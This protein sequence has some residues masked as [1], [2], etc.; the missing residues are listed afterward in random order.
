MYAKIDGL[1]TF[2][3]NVIFDGVNT[4][5]HISCFL[6]AERRQVGLPRLASTSG[7]DMQIS[8]A[9]LNLFLESE[10]IDYYTSGSKAYALDLAVPEP[11]IVLCSV[12]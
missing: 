12:N 9:D 11:T 3:F 8:Y 7:I 5:Y 4:S 2:N 10:T 6:K 1:A